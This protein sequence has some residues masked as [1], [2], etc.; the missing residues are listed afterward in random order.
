MDTL[1]L[2]FEGFG[3]ALTPTNILMTAGGGILGILVGAMPGIGSLLGCALLLPLTFKMNPTTAIVMLATIYYG[4]MYGGA[5]SAI[6]LNIPGDSP[7]IMTAMDGYPLMRKGRPGAALF[8]A[9]MASFCG[10]TIGILILTFLGV[11]L[12]DIGLMFGPSEMVAVMILS[13]SS[14]SWLLG[15]SPTKGLISTMLGI[16]IATIG[17]DGAT[18]MPRF[19]FGNISLLSGVLL[20]PLVIGVFGFSQVMQ[21]S[22]AK[23][24]DYNE[25]KSTKLRIRDAIITKKEAKYCAPIVVR[26]GLLGT[27]VGILPGSGATISAFLCYL[28]NK[29]VSKRGKEFGTGI[30][31]GIA[32]SEAA[33]NAAAAGAFAPLL[34]LGIP[35]SGTAAVLLSGLMM[36]GLTPG[37]QLF[38]DEPEFCWGLISSMYVGNILCL[39]M[40][41]LLIPLLVKLISVPSK[42]ICPVV[43]TMCFIGA[44]AASNE[45]NNLYVMLLGGLAGYF[46]N[47]YDYPTA[48]MLLSFVLTPTIEKN[49]YRSLMVSNGDLS[50]YWTRPITL[51]LLIVTVVLMV[52]PVVLKAVRKGKKAEA[53][54]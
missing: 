38:T 43:V 21:L 11:G 17:T 44:F 35:G 41:M 48:P 7:A 31:D 9:N 15:D 18:G 53:Q 10:G 16:M 30:P 24:T 5:Y 39:A 20:V 50:I 1:Q 6:L 37:P 26:S 4:N 33:N 22:H 47:K 28:M 12:A 45:V 14:I 40:G 32:A 19:T 46:M 13:L 8:T 42:L 23:E 34:A 36:W 2:L 54:Q 51:A 25:L 27:V 52:A 3:T 49:L 29:K